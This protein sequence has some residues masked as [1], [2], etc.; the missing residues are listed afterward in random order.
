MKDAFDG[1]VF[2][3]FGNMVKDTHD[4][5]ILTQ[6]LEGMKRFLFRG[7]EGTITQKVESSISG[8]LTDLFKQFESLGLV[9]KGDEGQKFF[10]DSIIEFLHSLT[11]VKITLAFEPS[12]TFIS[13]LNEQISKELGQKVVLDVIVN[14]FIVAGADFEYEGKYK[15]FSLALRID[16]FIANAVKGEGSVS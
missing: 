7:K 6:Q 3:P 15:D 8:Q 1:T 5:Y 11:I 14:Q 4:V 9:P 16:D 2:I 10:L 12:I 13:E